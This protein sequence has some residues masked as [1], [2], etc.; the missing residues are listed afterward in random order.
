[1]K[2]T[3]IGMMVLTAL[4]ALAMT[5]Q[6]AP[7]L[8]QLTWQEGG[9]YGATHALEFTAAD[10][11][12]YTATNTAIA[13]TNTVVAPYALEFRG[14]VL[15]L[16]FDSSTVTNP[17]SMTLSCGD[18][19]STTKWLSAVQVAYDATPTVKAS[20]GTDYSGTASV[21]LTATT[22]LVVITG[23]GTSSTYF[24]SGVSGSSAVTVASPYMNDQTANGAL[25]LSVS[26]P[27][28]DRVPNTLD[29]GKARVFFR[30]LG[31]SY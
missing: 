5:A 1:M 21:T 11:A 12:D 18:T 24:V 3:N 22:N 28:A 4:V 27:G 9:K 30:L 6:A 20:F 29:R 17:F 10:L 8:R 19:N 25:V 26:A 13:F 31:P 15:D 16:A 7:K 23:V 14:Y 2:R